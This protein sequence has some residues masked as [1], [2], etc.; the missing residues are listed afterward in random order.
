MLAKTLAHRFTKGSG[1]KGKQHLLAHNILKHE[2]AFLIIPD[3]GLFFRNRSFAGVAVGGFRAEDEVEV[4]GKVLRNGIEATGTKE[5][6]VAV[7]V[8]AK[9]NVFHDFLVTV[10]F[11][12][13]IGLAGDGEWTGL[14]HVRRVVHGAGGQSLVDFERF[15][16]EIE[17]G[18]Q[19]GP[20]AIFSRVR[21]R[22]RPRPKRVR[23]EEEADG[24]YPSG[25]GGQAV[26][27]IGCVDP[28]KGENGP[29]ASA[30][31][32]G[33]EGLE[34]DPGQ[35]DLGEDALFEDGAE[36]DEVGTS[37]GCELDFGEGM[38]ANA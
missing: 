3:L 37:I 28:T 30:L 24:R 1:G 11:H 13:K 23:G 10:M 21:L 31:A 26:G 32:G 6:E 20:V 2:P 9:A 27:E 14:E 36:E 18:N 22:G 38:G 16:G 4:A 29:G 5:G 19:H 7:V 34:P 33:G 12:E 35:N 17:R 15:F 25:A 8:G